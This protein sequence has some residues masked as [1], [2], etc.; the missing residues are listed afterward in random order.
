[1]SKGTWAG[2]HLDTQDRSKGDRM[3]AQ[4]SLVSLCREIGCEQRCIVLGGLDCRQKVPSQPPGL[5]QGKARAGYHVERPGPWKAAV[6]AVAMQVARDRRLERRGV[7]LGKLWELRGW[8]GDL[9]ILGHGE[10]RLTCSSHPDT[11]V[12]VLRLGLTL[13]TSQSLS[14][15]PFSPPS[16]STWLSWEG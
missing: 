3:W 15:Q 12:E 7:L 11:G 14:S 6:K 8:G 2:W 5:S 13:G 4:A 9:G 16:P 1:M 10:P